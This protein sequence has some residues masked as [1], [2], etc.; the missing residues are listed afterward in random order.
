[1]G[2]GY[3]NETLRILLDYLFY[4][5]NLNRVM[6]KTS[7]TN[8]SSIKGLQ[9][10]GFKIEGQ[11]RK[12]YRIDKDFVDANIMSILSTILFQFC[13]TSISQFLAN[14]FALFFSKVLVSKIF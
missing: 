1:M 11:M 8:T 10:V 2:K 13:I 5:I 12:F 3:F 4:I 14:N 9:K 7:I 6:A